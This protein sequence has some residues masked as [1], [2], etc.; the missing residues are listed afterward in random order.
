MQCFLNHLMAQ[1][2]TF[3]ALIND[4]NAIALLA[5]RLGEDVEVKDVL[6][7]SNTRNK[8]LQVSFDSTREY[9]KID[10]IETPDE[11]DA[12]RESR[13][14]IRGGGRETDE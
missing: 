3:E 1:H 10:E 2:Q 6:R 11:D 13:S 7:E 9:L 14:L 5:V 12:T 4:P 8:N